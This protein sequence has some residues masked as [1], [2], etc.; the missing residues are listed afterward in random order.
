MK[1][2]L[3]IILLI[4]V[5]F[6]FNA[7]TEKEP[8]SENHQPIKTAYIDYYGVKIDLKNVK[9]KEISPMSM[10]GPESTL[11]EKLESL[12]ENTQHQRVLVRAECMSDM[13]QKIYSD[14]THF[15]YHFSDGGDYRR[16][17]IAMPFKI[18]EILYGDESIIKEGDEVWV[19]CLEAYLD[20]GCL[21]YSSIVNS[22]VW[23]TSLRTAFNYLGSTHRFIFPRI[24]YEY[25]II[26]SYHKKTNCYTSK[27]ALCELSDLEDYYEYHSN[28]YNYKGTSVDESYE[29]IYKDVLKK[30]NLKIKNK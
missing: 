22:Q 5:V 25:V 7:C 1:R 6:T 15:N 11:E 17:Y 12:S 23:P 19:E 29:K 14:D 8:S 3:S 16:Q 26:L 2:I 30:F 9:T 20:M 18:K 10:L 4:I 24:G 21:E 28:V 13:I 27:G